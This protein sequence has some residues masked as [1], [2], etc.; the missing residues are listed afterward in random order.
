M[1]AFPRP[2]SSGP[3]L[4]F[5][6]PSTFVVRSI[7][8]LA[9]LISKLLWQVRYRGLDNIPNG[10]DGLLIVSNH[11]TYIDP[12]WI[13]IPIRLKLR[14]MAWDQVFEWPAIGRLIRILGAFPV[15][16]R[17]G[18]SVSAIA[19]AL[20]SLRDGAALVIF[21]EGER[22]FED[23]RLLDFK[24]GAAHIAVKAGVPILPVSIRGGNR[25]WPRGKKYPRIFRSVEI[26]FHPVIRVQDRRHDA[27]RDTYLTEVNEKLVAVIAS[28]I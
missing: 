28:A 20:R 27:D 1:P 10:D 14:Y 23:G 15:K 22:E 19:E 13:S 21:P 6:Y 25:I 11:P 2:A 3:H 24:T 16:H 12:V 18:I 8:A 9:L 7:R 5:K 17:S 4:H 26:I